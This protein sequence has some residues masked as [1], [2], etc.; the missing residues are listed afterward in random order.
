MLIVLSRNVIVFIANFSVGGGAM[1]VSKLPL[2]RALKT[3][4]PSHLTVA[5][6]YECD[7]CW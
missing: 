4:R 2:C 7:S 1:G 6:M 3:Q 5:E